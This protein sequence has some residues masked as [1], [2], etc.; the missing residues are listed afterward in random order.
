MGAVEPEEQLKL[1]T[2]FRERL[3]SGDSACTLRPFWPD[4]PPQHAE[5]HRYNMVLKEELFQPVDARGALHR[6]MV[7]IEEGF[8][9]PAETLLAMHACYREYLDAGG[10]LSLEEAMQGKPVQRVGTV[11]AQVV[12]GRKAFARDFVY[13]AEFEIA[14]KEGLDESPA[15]ARAEEVTARLFGWAPDADSW[16]KQHRRAVKRRRARLGVGADKKP[17]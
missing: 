1:E 11:A 13:R 12:K 6:A 8:M 10:S 7:M 17:L 16:L 4:A 14:L 2:R 5:L 3:D 9:P 15:A